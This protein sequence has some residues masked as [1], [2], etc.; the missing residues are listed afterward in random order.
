LQGLHALEVLQGL[1]GLQPFFTA[2]GLHGLQGLQAFFTA[3]GLHGLQAPQAFFFTAQGLQGLQAPQ[4]TSAAGFLHA[5]GITRVTRGEQERLPLGERLRRRPGIRPADRGNDGW[6]G[7]RHDSTQ[8]RRAKR[9]A[10]HVDRIERLL[11][12]V[13]LSCTN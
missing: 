13:L 8:D 3:Q 5:A 12:F 11:H 9:F 6:G 4:A 2:Q 10:I 7:Y 1:Q